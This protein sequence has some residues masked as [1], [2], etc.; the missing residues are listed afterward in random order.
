MREALKQRAQSASR[1][2][3]TLS[4]KIEPK[5]EAHAHKPDDKS[6]KNTP[7]TGEPV[8]VRS[9][10]EPLNQ[11][12]PQFDK[13]NIEPQTYSTVEIHQQADGHKQKPQIVERVNS[14]REFVTETKNTSHIEAIRFTQ[15]PRESVQ[16]KAETTKP[17]P[18]HNTQENISTQKPVTD[19]EILSSSLPNNIFDVAIE[20]VTTHI[21]H[22][23]K[24]LKETISQA[25]IVEHIT[26]IQSTPDTPKLQPESPTIPDITQLTERLVQTH[27]EADR[28]L[29]TAIAFLSNE[30]AHITVEKGEIDEIVAVEI[31]DQPAI[32]IKQFLIAAQATRLDISGVIHVP[33][34]GEIQ[35]QLTIHEEIFF[36]KDENNTWHIKL[37]IEER[38]PVKIIAPKPAIGLLKQ[39]LSRYLKKA[40]YE[41]N[42]ELSVAEEENQANMVSVSY[43]YTNDAI[44]FWLWYL[45]LKAMFLMDPW[46]LERTLITK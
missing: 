2:D 41:E 8:A 31:P 43:G 29:F 38:K 34:Q 40:V 12:Q 24:D 16:P 17:I 1:P 3:A 19:G 4:Q 25:P 10:A 7:G 18:T 22:I 33:T 6:R 35:K 37:L 46:E 14:E 5:H 21:D 42:K 44:V 26:Q 9:Y 45:E 27:T 15:A 20:P 32:I 36:I 23:V 39:R 28:A 13:K 11:T 30:E